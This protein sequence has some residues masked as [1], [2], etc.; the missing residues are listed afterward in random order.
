MIGRLRGVLV[1]SRESGIVID[2]GGVGYEVAMTTRDLVALPGIGEE[3]VV[4]CHTHVRE[5]ELSLYGFANERDREIFRV[6]LTA[7]G[8][9]PKVAIAMLAA[10]T[11][12]EIVRAITGEDPDALTVT[13]GVGKRGAQKI[14]LELGPKLAGRE[15]EV[16]G[17]QSLGGVRQ[18]LEGLGYSTAEINAVVAD[19]DPEAPI[20]A[21][22]KAALQR[23]GRL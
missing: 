23:L 7:S 4:H 9:G 8:V 11:S 17:S 12:D 14:V 1:S 13:P 20:E 19:L 6:L 5:D 21:Q 15:I 22:V 2:V 18:A 3:I 10:M 16:I